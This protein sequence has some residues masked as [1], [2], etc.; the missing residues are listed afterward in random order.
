MARVDV[1]VLVWVSSPENVLLVLGLEMSTRA[2]ELT[3]CNR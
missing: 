3:P 2:D 1:V